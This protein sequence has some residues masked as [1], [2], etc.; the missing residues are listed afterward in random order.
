M[1]TT[2]AD[3]DLF[4][5]TSLQECPNSLFIFSFVTEVVVTF[6]LFSDGISCAPIYSEQE[7]YELE[8]MDNGFLLSEDPYKFH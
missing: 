7:L 6:R 4:Y 3:L 5:P 8:Y 2:E 1:R